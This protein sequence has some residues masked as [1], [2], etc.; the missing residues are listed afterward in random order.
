MSDLA[1]LLTD[2]EA[3]LELAY[4]MGRLEVTGQVN[5]QRIRALKERYDSL[6]E[7]LET[8]PSDELIRKAKRLRRQLRRACEVG[9]RNEAQLEKLT[10][11]L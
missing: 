10:D 8:T 6:R 2:V 9:I 7:Q 4:Q 11:A 5:I 1:A 3:A